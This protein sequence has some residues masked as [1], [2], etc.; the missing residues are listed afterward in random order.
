MVVIGRT[1]SHGNPENGTMLPFPGIKKSGKKALYING[2]AVSNKETNLIPSKIGGGSKI[3]IGDDAPGLYDELFIWR[4]VLSPNEIKLIFSQPDK[5]AAQIMAAS[6][7]SGTN[8]KRASVKDINFK[9]AIPVKNISF[10]VPFD[11]SVQPLKAS[12]PK[13]VNS[14]GK[15]NFS[16]GIVNQ[17]VSTHG[18]K[19]NYNPEGN[20]DITQ[21]TLSFWVKLNQ[22]LKSTKGRIVLFRAGHFVLNIEAKQQKL[23]FMTGLHNGEYFRWSYYPQTRLGGSWKAGKWHHIAIVWNKKTGRKELYIDAKLAGKANSSYMTDKISPSGEM[24]IG[25]HLNGK[26]RRISLFQ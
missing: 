19:I 25:N 17:A 9:A 11:G 24:Y 10:Y 4:R 7:K 21:G 2:K 14:A 20:F 12:G 16:K 6:R 8:V 13:T 22:A 23:L 18:S 1:K 3:S 26:N 5:V 15:A